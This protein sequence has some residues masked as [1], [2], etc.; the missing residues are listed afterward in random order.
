MARPF[1]ARTRRARKDS[2]EREGT[3]IMGTIGDYFRAAQ[4]AAND[5]ARA[6]A[7]NDLGRIATVARSEAAANAALTGA[8][9][10]ATA[11]AARPGRGRKIL[12]A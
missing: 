9:L 1:P 6:A 10:Q 12:P 3:R 4:E 11:S 8:I 2:R 5:R 7:A